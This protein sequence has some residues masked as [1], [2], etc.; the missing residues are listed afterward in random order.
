VPSPRYGEAGARARFAS[1]IL[2][3]SAFESVAT[4]T[5][6]NPASLRS[7]SP[8]R[9]RSFRRSDEITYLVGNTSGFTRRAAQQRRPYSSFFAHSLPDEDPLVR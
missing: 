9:G 7:S 4:A 5:L 2:V 3:Q 1:R 6:R 8:I